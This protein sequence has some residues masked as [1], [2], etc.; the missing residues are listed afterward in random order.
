[1][2]NFVSAKPTFGT[3]KTQ[4]SQ[5]D[6]INRKKE[7]YIIPKLYNKSN[8]ANNANNVNINTS[9]LIFG[10][11]SKLNLTNVCTVSKGAPPSKYCS[12]IIPCNPCQNTDTVTLSSTIPFCWGQTIDPL[13]ELFG[14]SQCGELNFT[15]YTVINLP[16]YL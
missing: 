2:F 7:K 13:G 14:S 16:N 3:L 8:F 6:Y 10:Q 5:S 11:Y 4:M 12:S 9:N 15:K 1:M